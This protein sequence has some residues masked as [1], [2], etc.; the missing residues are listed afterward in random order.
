MG[1]F[2][3]VFGPSTDSVRGHDVRF[4]KKSSTGGQAFGDYV[5]VEC[6]E[7][8][9]SKHA[10]LWSEDCAGP[11]RDGGH[12]TKPICL[13]VKSTADGGRLWGRATNTEKRSDFA[14]KFHRHNTDTELFEYLSSLRKGD[15]LSCVLIAAD[16]ELQTWTVEKRVSDDAVE[17]IEGRKYIAEVRE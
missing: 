16:A 10:I 15:Y 14:I 8:H 7:S 6:D 1:L 12:V 17:K 2:K 13:V 9:H 3:R 4:N 5:C 11:P